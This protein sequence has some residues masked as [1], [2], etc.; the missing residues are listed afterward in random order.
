MVQ[1][2]VNLSK[3]DVLSWN[4]PE[5][6]D[7]NHDEICQSIMSCRR[8][9]NWA[10]AERVRSQKLGQLGQSKCLAKRLIMQYLVRYIVCRKNGYVYR[11]CSRLF[12]ITS[13]G[14]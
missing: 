1:I 14:L 12:V 5:W 10:P 7:E 3:F 2:S 6:A 9:P 8:D 13:L 11:K 4:V